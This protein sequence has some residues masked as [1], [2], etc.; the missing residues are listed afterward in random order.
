MIVSHINAHVQSGLDWLDN[1]VVPGLREG[2]GEH[3][4]QVEVHG[5]SADIPEDEESDGGT[6][7]NPGPAVYIIQKGQL[8]NGIQKTDNDPPTIPLRFFCY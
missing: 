6:P 1:I 7:E 2:A 8:R 5:N 4:W 3:E